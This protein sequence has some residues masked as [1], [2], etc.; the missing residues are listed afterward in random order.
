MKKLF[1][2]PELDIYSLKFAQ[3]KIMQEGPS[4]VLDDDDP[5]EG[6]VELPKV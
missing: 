2:D 5:V 4:G 1:N 3:D 6:G